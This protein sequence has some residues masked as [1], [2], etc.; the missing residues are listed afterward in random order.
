MVLAGHVAAV[1][2]HHAPGP[3]EQPAAD[4]VGGARAEQALAAGV[5]QLH[6]AVRGDDGDPLAQHLDDARYCASVWRARA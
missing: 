2:V 5:E 6:G 3:V 4:E 1:L